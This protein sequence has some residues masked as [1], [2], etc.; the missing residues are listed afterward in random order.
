MD[1]SDKLTKIIP[2]FKISEAMHA[3]VL[4]SAKRHHSKLIDHVRLL[5][6][7]GL[8]YQAALDANEA[9]VLTEML[10]PPDDLVKKV[11]PPSHKEQKK[12]AC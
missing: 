7:Q 11:A 9:R 12:R 10:K 5:I 3:E 4:E 1:D 2:A 8:K 6:A